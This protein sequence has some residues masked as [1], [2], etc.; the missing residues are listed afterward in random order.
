MRYKNRVITVILVLIAVLTG[1]LS[2]CSNERRAEPAAI[3]TVSNVPVT[4]AQKTTVPDW[5]EAVGTV[6]AAQTSQVSSQMM[7]NIIEIRSHEGDRVQNGQV[8]ATIDD[9]QPRSAADQAKAAL[10]VAENEVS[11]ADSDL[12]LSQATLLRYQQLYDKKSVSPQEFDEIK[13]RYQS[14]E[15]RRDMTRAG[16]A[17]ASAALTQAQTSLSYTQIRAPFSGVVTEKKAD[18]GTLVSPGMPIFTLEDT[19]GFRLEV[20]VDET[21]IHLVH[22]GQIAMVSI[23][24]LGNIQLSGKIAQI[25]PAADTDSHSFLVKVELP[26][27]TRLRSGLFGRA[28]FARSERSALLIPRTSLVER[29]Q[30]QGVYVLDANQIAGLRYVT[31][32]RST[33]EQV[34]VLSGLQAGEKFFAAP[35]DR[36]L[37]GKRIAIGQ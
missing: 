27:D 34:E 5:L 32:G 1:G 19:R 22:V 2:G 28:Q 8:L 35:G 12:V 21:D 26:V 9:A 3:E 25:V 33:G 20:T 17:Q 15:A 23:D 10:A 7:A 11:A 31:L 4:V 24:G 37:G 13:A 16:K 6:R 30:L 29:G 14:A 36:E 18:V